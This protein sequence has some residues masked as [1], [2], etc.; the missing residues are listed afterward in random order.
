MKK[1]RM[2]RLVSKNVFLFYIFFFLKVG[3]CSH[4]YDFYVVL[5]DGFWLMRITA[6]IFCS[7]FL[8]KS[9]HI[10]VVNAVFGI[11]LPLLMY[12]E[13]ERAKGGVKIL[14]NSEGVFL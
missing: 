2:R 1:C 14:C 9:F 12:V 13:T 4:E 7:V 6:D 5:L 8:R 11:Y 3:K 10:A